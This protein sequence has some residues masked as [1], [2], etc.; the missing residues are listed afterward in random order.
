MTCT[1]Y[2]QEPSSD[3]I[4]RAEAIKAIEEKAKRI[5]NKNCGAKMVEPQ[6][7]SEE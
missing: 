1:Y 4:S 2:K 7:R 5:T 3:L 6:E